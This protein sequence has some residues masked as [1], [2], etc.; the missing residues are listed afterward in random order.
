MSHRYTHKDS[1]TGTVTT[2]SG[3]CTLNVDAVCSTCATAMHEQRSVLGEDEIALLRDNFPLN[4]D[5]ALPTTIIQCTH[6]GRD[7]WDIPLPPPTQAFMLVVW[8]GMLLQDLSTVK[9]ATELVCIT[10]DA[11]ETMRATK[12]KCV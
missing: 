3:G 2:Q 4:H 9:S 12:C 10:I 5:A 11:S 6:C 7:P 1:D 8:V